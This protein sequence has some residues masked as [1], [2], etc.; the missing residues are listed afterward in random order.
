LEGAVS[1]IGKTITKVELT[2]CDHGIRLHF[3]DGTVAAGKTDGDCCSY[4]WIEHV[5]L[6]AMGFP[7]T[8]TDWRDL[9]LDRA[10]QDDDGD[11]IAFYGLEIVTDRGSLVIDY[12]N[13]SNGYYGGSLEWG[14]D[15]HYY[16][17]VH[18]QNIPTGE[19]VELTEDK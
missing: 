8:I 10:D 14:D 2:S 1:Y 16:G 11:V 15:G 12:R 13:S 5:S 3:S 7:A 9:D 4:T 17:G 6:P 19:W 18:D